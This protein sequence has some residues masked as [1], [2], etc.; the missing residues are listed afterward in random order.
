[1]SGAENARVRADIVFFETPQGGG[2]FTTGSISWCASLAHNG[3]DNN[4]ARMTGN[5]LR[6]FLSP[7]PL[8]M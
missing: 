6:R 8:E 4:V 5:V 1:M 3:Y 7:E 2:V